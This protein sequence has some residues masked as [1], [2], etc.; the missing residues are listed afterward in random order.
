MKTLKSGFFLTAFSFAA[1]FHSSCDQQKKDQLALWSETSPKTD[2]TTFVEK[3]TNPQSPDFVP[4]DDR[5]AVFDND[6]TLWTEY[7]V[8]NQ[9]LFAIDILH[10]IAEKDTAFEN[11]EPYSKFLDSL[12]MS[13]GDISTHDLLALIQKT[14]SGFSTTEFRERSAE[15]MKT[16]K[17]PLLQ[18]TITDLSYSPM[19]ELINYLNENEFQVYIVSGGGV[20]FIRAI[21]EDIYGIPVNHI[22][23]SRMETAYNPE[24]GEIE[25]QSKIEFIDDKEGKPVGI[26]TVIGKRPILVGGNS[27]GDLAMMEYAS[28][29]DYPFLNL[30]VHHTDADRE[31]SYD[32]NSKI[33]H[34]DKALQV[35]KDQNWTIIDMAADWKQIH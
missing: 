12:W 27:D 29:G 16:T 26:N 28:K 34:L 13:N 5:I 35:A 19:V 3:I 18:K 20:E 2:I 7:P 33:G 8:Y 4:V 6:G 21:S 15:W 1:L 14:H 17:H 25:L 23:G 24:S 9:L 10:E 22:I 30:L 31:F 11:K 32:V